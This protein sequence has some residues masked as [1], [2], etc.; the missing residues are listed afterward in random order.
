MGSLVRSIKAAVGIKAT[1]H[2]APRREEVC[3]PRSIVIWA[4]ILSRASF[5]FWLRLGLSNLPH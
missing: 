2:N 1:I 4:A 3:Q 5:Q